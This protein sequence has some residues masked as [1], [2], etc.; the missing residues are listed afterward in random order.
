MDKPTD[1]IA[2]LEAEFTELYKI[3]KFG[4]LAHSG[5]F[6]KQIIANGQVCVNGEVETRK[7]KKIVA[8]DNIEVGGQS[9]KVTSKSGW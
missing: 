1:I 7:R 4:N 3:L 2:E 6:A 8:G 5:G 9:I